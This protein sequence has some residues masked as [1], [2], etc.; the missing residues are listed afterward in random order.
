VVVRRETLKAI[1]SRYRI[2]SA[3]IRTANPKLRGTRL[4]AGSR[5]V[6]PTVAVPSALAMRAAGVTA[7]SR[8]SLAARTHRVRRGET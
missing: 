3:E 6:I 8:A 7:G 4:K 1:A 2:P 5:L